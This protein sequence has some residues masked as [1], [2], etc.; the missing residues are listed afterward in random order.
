MKRVH[1][2][3]ICCNWSPYACYTAAGMARMKIPPNFRLLRVMCIGRINQ[4]LILRA[5]EFG[6]DGVIVL[7]CKDED[8]RY[9]PGPDVGHVNV[10]RVR[11]LLSLLGIGQ[12]RLVERDFASHE[13]SE[14][15]QALWDF[16]ER[17]EAMGPNPAKPREEREK[18]EAS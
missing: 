10:A 5:F 14:L 12:D 15:V 1:L 17:I 3:G 7:E 8:C 6:A 13:K 9:G 2:L 11:Q 18:R 4:S 16:A